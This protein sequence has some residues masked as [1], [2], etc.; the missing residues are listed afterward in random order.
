VRGDSIFCHPAAALLSEWDVGDAFSATPL[1]LNLLQYLDEMWG[2][3][4]SATLLYSF[5]RKEENPPISNE[6]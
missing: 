6:L 3:A 1:Q 5:I 4:F 2:D